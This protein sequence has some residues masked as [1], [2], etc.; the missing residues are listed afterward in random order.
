MNK[1]VFI[2]EF[3]ANDGSPAQTK[4]LLRTIEESEIPLAALW[5]FDAS[6]LKGSIEIAPDNA[7]AWQLREVG[8]AN[9]RVAKPGATTMAENP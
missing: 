7:L 5:V 1:P 6:P 9:K 3:S 8:E 2:S 4:S